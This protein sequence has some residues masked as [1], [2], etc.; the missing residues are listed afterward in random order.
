MTKYMAERPIKAAFYR[1]LYEVM[2][3]TTA[4]MDGDIS[5][6]KQKEIELARSSLPN[7]AQGN[8]IYEGTNTITA[9]D[10]S[11]AQAHSF[12]DVGRFTP[13]SGQARRDEAYGDQLIPSEFAPNGLLWSFAGAF[14]FNRDPRDLQGRDLITVG[15]GRTKTDQVIQFLNAARLSQLPDWLGGRGWD[16]AAAWYNDKPYN[17]RGRVYTLSELI[18]DGFGGSRRYDVLDSS[19]LERLRDY[20][21]R[22]ASQPQTSEEYNTSRLYPDAWN[23]M[24]NRFKKNVEDQYEAERFKR[25]VKMQRAIEKNE[26]YKNLEKQLFGD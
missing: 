20:Q 9:A 7:W 15:A 6:E 25:D 22:G 5:E 12:Y 3:Q 13:M 11:Q 8:T 23:E 19:R 18:A 2:G 17:A 21:M 1:Q 10:G 14:A 4:T 24:R 26:A 16:K